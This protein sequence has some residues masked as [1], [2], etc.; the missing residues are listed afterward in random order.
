MLIISTEVPDF[1]KKIH[2]NMKVESFGEFFL[3]TVPTEIIAGNDIFIE[4]IIEDFKKYNYLYVRIAIKGDKVYHNGKHYTMGYNEINEPILTEY[5][6]N[7]IIS[8]VELDLLSGYYYDGIE[9]ISH[10]PQMELSNTII[11]LFGIE[12]LI[13]YLND[14]NILKKYVNMIEDKEKIHEL[15]LY[16]KWVIHNLKLIKSI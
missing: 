11:K 7:N 4:K 9:K 15:E 1:F 2:S 10:S 6:N 5:V 16:D 13:D 14:N 8:Y 12:S 3:K